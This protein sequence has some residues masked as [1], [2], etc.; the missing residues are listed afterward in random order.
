MT[1]YTTFEKGTIMRMPLTLFA[2]YNKDWAMR[3]FSRQGQ[4]EKCTKNP[5]AIS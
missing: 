1:V 2:R 4:Y 5:N 3:S